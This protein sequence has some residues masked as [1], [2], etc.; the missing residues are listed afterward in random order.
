LTR[1]FKPICK[2]RRVIFW[3][4]LHPKRYPHGC[5]HANGGRASNHQPSYGIAHLVH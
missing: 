4:I 2:S 5:G 1:L 3:G